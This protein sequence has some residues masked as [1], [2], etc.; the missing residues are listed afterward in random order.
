MGVSLKKT[1]NNFKRIK[2]DTHEHIPEQKHTHRHGEQIHDC[3]RGGE[4]MGWTGNL[5]LVDANS[6][7]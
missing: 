2:Y 1:K 4:G 6:Y 3:Q 7:I 5:G